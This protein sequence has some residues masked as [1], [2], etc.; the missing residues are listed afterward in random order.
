[1]KM[2]RGLA[3]AKY[4]GQGAG[5]VLT[6]V[7]RNR[8]STWLLR[9][10]KDFFNMSAQSQHSS[11]IAATGPHILVVN[12][13]QEI[14]DLFK[15]L[16][17]GEGYRVSLYSYAFKDIAD[18]RSLAPDLVILDFIIGG[19][20]HGWQMLQKMKMDRETANIPVIIC[21]AAVQLV[22]ELEGHLT[23]KNI[24][25]LL[26]PFDIDELLAEVAGVMAQAS[27]AD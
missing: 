26:K 12:D 8:V 20:A 11:A 2:R 19:E 27:P 1:M 16:L 5:E 4:T 3:F 18:I 9:Y 6:I 17:E 13:T 24:R 22:K 23:S 10:Q 15:E 14:L 7:V 21:S 25:V